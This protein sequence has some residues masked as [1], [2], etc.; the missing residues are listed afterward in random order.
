MVRS[1]TKRVV[2]AKTGGRDGELWDA[3]SQRRCRKIETKELDKDEGKM[4]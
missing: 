2:S 4:E 3:W 1:A